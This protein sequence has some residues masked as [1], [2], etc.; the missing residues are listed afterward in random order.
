MQKQTFKQEASNTK[1]E[2]ELLRQRS[3]KPLQ[4][5]EG[6]LQERDAW[7]SCSSWVDEVD[8]QILVFQMYQDSI[9]QKVSKL[10]QMQLAEQA[11]QERMSQRGRSA[12]S[13]AQE[14][15]PL[16]ANKSRG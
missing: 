7:G 10:T 16:K 8:S 1:K 12:E 9:R 14:K 2:Q 6:S 3:P 11:M 5:E 4:S 13:Q 15:T